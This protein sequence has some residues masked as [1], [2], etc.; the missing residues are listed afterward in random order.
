MMENNKR[1]Y[2]LN[3]EELNA[4]S[5]G[6]LYGDVEWE[7]GDRVAVNVSCACC[8]K[9]GVT[10]VISTVYRPKRGGIVRVSVTMDCCGGV[11]TYYLSDG[12]I[13]KL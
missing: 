12:Q 7:E 13:T 8:G 2:E 10:G 9:T 11:A 1:P 5:G 4:V 3:D 6:I